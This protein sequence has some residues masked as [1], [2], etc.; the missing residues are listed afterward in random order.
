MRFDVL[1]LFPAMFDS[2][3]GESILGKAVEKGLIR[4]KAHYLRDWAQGRHLVTDDA[5]YG[6]GDGMLLKPEPV[7][8]AVE[9]IRE[10]SPA[11]L[12]VMLTPQGKPFT[13]AVARELAQA[14]GLILLCGRYEG[15]DE[16]IRENLA[17]R[18]YSIGDYILTGGELGAMVMID[19][20]SRLIPGVLGGPDS[21]SSD[22]FSDGLL[23]HPH[24]TRPAEFRGMRVPDVLLSGDHARIARWRR[25]QQLERTLKRRPDLLETAPLTEQD[26]KYLAALMASGNQEEP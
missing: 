3:L 4:F 17:D 23:E 22:S 12:V 19:A 15:F 18:E 21:A 6:G 26:R 24:Y 13:Q 20:V 16:R 10:Q 25:Q 8:R 1:S 9:A 7:F 5:P 2:P 14:P 11:S